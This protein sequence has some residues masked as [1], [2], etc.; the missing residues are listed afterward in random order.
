MSLQ[1]EQRGST[2]GPWIPKTRLGR[3]VIEG[4]ITSLNEIFEQGW[5]IREVGII[6]FLVPDKSTGFKLRYKDLPLIDLEL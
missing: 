6:D 1:G 5:K 3:M 4:Q 2:R